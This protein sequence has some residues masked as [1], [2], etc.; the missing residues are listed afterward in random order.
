[1]STSDRFQRAME[2]FE[3][4]CDLPTDARSL[5]LND[6]CGANPE[7]REEVESLLDSDKTGELFDAVESGAAVDALAQ[8]VSDEEPAAIAEHIGAY[9]VIRKLGEGGMGE[10]YEAEQESPKRLVAL[11]V[12]RAGQ[13]SPKLIKRFEHEAFVLGQLQHPGIAHI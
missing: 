3:H 11:K 1:M 7:L 6:A 2:I 4:A 8:S 9:R 12:I 5:Y 10:V 13:V